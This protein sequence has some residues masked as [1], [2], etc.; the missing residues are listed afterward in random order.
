[1]NDR[2]TVKENLVLAE[3]KA[4]Q[5]FEEI[6]KQG[7]VVP[8]KTEKELNN[9]VYELSIAL[10]DSR[11]HW[12]KR[13]VRS[14][15]NTLYP[16]KENPPNLVIQEND[17]LFFD[18]GPILEEWEADIGRTYV[19][20]NDPDKLKL[21]EDIEDCWYKAQQWFDNQEDCTGAALFA[22][23]TALAN[24]CGWE[25]GGE[26][27]GH[28]IGHFPHEKLKPGSQ[29]LYIHPENQQHLKSANNGMVRDWIL[30][31]HFVNREKEI[32]GFF[33]QLLT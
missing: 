17:I 11:K 7:L 5:L 16:Y 21:K 8:G 24:K 22:H 33:E 26:I 23:C 10:L 6:E 14:G 27:A 13:I 29:D 18:F 3:R 32:G 15:R 28:T 12:H 20:G 25:F 19:L 4:L 9:E 30:E 31:I 2:D 1:M